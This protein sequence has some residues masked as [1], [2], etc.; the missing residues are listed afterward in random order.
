[1]VMSWWACIKHV[2]SAA[3]MPATLVHYCRGSGGVGGMSTVTASA[4]VWFDLGQ[5]SY[6][7][8]YSLIADVALIHF[9]RR[10]YL[11]LSST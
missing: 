3:D 11:S 6:I 10:R 4:I 9:H 8:Q 2:A 1:M 7:P 5:C